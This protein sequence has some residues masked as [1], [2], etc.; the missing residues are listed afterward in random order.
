M[1]GAFIRMMINGN[2]DTYMPGSAGDVDS[3]TGNGE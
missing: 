2:N 3:D 1:K